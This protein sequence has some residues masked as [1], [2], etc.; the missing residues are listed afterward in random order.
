[1]ILKKTYIETYQE[2]MGLFQTL[3]V[4]WWWAILALL[5]ITFPLWADPYFVYIVNW[6]AIFVVAG[7][8]LNILTGAAGQ[9]SLCQ[10]AMVGVGGYVTAILCVR[11]NM[12]FWITLPMS[13]IIAAALAIIIGVISLRV[14][15]LYLAMAT[16]AFGVFVQYIML[17]WES[18]TNGPFGINVP[19]MTIG[20]FIFNTNERLYYVFLIVTVLLLCGAKN[21]LRTRPGRAFIAIR[22]RD[23]AAEC[24]GVNLSKYKVIAF[25]LSAFYAG[26][27]G[28]VYAHLTAYMNPEYFTFVLSVESLIVIIVGGLGSVLGTILGAIFVV[29]LPEFIKGSLDMLTLIFPRLEG[30]YN[31]DWN[32]ATFGLAII[33]CLLF[34]PNGM[35]G[36]YFRI[37]RF[38]KDWP[39]S[40]W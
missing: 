12:P 11:L 9:I 19:R 24:M 5:L 16:M 33:L 20:G 25:A 10:G 13:G 21:I 23:I 39:F 31:D 22:D 38:C 15:G 1:M 29:V 28:W 36:I 30:A 17:H 35:A 2:D 7:A 8:G 32:I 14:K 6:I 27:A 26:V 18:L 40:K 4:K 3:W 37:K 34:E